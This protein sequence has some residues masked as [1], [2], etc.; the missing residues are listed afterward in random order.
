MRDAKHGSAGKEEILR[1]IPEE[2]L[3]ALLEN[4]YEGLILVDEDGIVRFM[5]SATEGLYPISPA[6]A[7]GRHINEVSPS[8]RLP[9]VIEA[10]KAEI[11]S[12]MEIQEGPRVVARIP[13][14][15]G[16]RVIGAF[17]KLMFWTPEKLRELYGRVDTLEKHLNYYKNE[18]EQGCGV[19]YG[20]EDIFGKSELLRQTIC[21][22]NQ[23][24]ETDSPVLIRGESGTGKELF[25]HAIH[26][27]SRRR[28]NNF[29]KLNCASIPGEL[30]ESELFGYEAGSFTGAGKAGRPGKFELANNGTI[31]LDEIGDMSPSMQVKIMRVLQ[32]KEIDRIGSR[33]AKPVDFRLI[34]ATN[35]DLEKMMS[36]GGFRLDLYYRIN[37]FIINLPALREIKEDLPLIFTHFLQDLSGGRHRVPSISADSMELLK[38]YSWPGNIREL[39]NIAERALIVCKNNK[40]EPEDLPPVFRTPSPLSLRSDQDNPSSTLKDLLEETELCA[41]LST[42]K[43]SGNNRAKTAQILGIHRTGLYQKMKKYKII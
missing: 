17:G 2:L 10:G 35:R 8:S 19:R 39:R 18:S 16:D 22:A 3:H 9:M 20:F 25:A 12:T 41:I 1:S 40:I 27:A 21:L 31:F 4:P 7:I 14:T 37:V 23:A 30:I 28:K 34:C 36:E 32:E 29:I 13:L 11:G 26:Q 5:S 38:S 43:K 33:R 24:G 6:K 15:Q 42:L